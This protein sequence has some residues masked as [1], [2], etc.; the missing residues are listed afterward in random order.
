MSWTQNQTEDPEATT[1]RVS[2][3]LL[4]LSV[5]VPIL[6][7]VFVFLLFCFNRISRLMIWS[8]SCHVLV[9]EPSYHNSFCSLFIVLSAWFSA[10][11]WLP[12]SFVCIFELCQKTKSLKLV[13]QTLSFRIE[14]VGE[15]KMF[16]WAYWNWKLAICSWSG[17]PKAA[18][19]RGWLGILFSDFRAR[20]RE[21]YFLVQLALVATSGKEV[22]IPPC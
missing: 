8:C 4:T 16:P 11:N 19:G 20:R 21:G 15:T 22:F 12:P 17:F 7:H 10:L 2:K 1:T 13:Q 14:A 18:W 9:P 5:F 6:H 3:N